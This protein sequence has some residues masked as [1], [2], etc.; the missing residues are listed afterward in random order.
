MKC[1]TNHKEVNSIQREAY[2][3]T[4]KA[5]RLCEEIDTQRQLLVWCGTNVPKLRAGHYI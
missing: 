4:E 1:I 2:S 3:Q 5:K